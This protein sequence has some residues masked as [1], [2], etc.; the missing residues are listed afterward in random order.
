MANPN[1]A[2]VMEQ[3]VD[4]GVE[5][6]LDGAQIYGVWSAGHFFRIGPV[7]EDAPEE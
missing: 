5:L 4:L 2:N 6:A 1:F 3:L 7:P